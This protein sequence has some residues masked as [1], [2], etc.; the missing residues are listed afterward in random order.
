MN[1][2]EDIKKGDHERMIYF[3]K[4]K[5]RHEK[6]LEELL[7]SNSTIPEEI[8]FLI[9]T[10]TKDTVFAEYHRLLAEGK[11]FEGLQYIH[12]DDT[13]LNI[14]TQL[15]D[16]YQKYALNQIIEI[17]HKVRKMK[18]F[19][20]EE[21][22]EYQEKLK[23]VKALNEKEWEVFQ[24]EVYEI[25]SKTQE[26]KMNEPKN[27]HYDILII[28]DDISVPVLLEKYFETKGITCK[29]ITD[30]REVLK[31]LEHYH[32][33]VILVD[34]MMP[35]IYG[36]ELC[37]QI[38]SNPNTNHIPVFLMGDWRRIEY[39][40]KECKADGYIIEPFDFSDLDDII[41]LL[42]K[43]NIPTGE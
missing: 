23:T 6:Y 3:L 19:T 24:E 40:L 1:A 37:K 13:Y 8:N 14:K 31:E 9:S 26:L 28:D 2:I 11:N 20:G 5:E 39:R 16:K 36:W 42:K 18:H 22:E 7:Q 17:I 43:Y 10:L 34:D 41:N 38:K 25:K 27:P 29:G 35:Y 4:C 32:P 30:E 12:N 15:C 33:K 21:W